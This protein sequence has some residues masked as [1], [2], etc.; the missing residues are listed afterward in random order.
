MTNPFLDIAGIKTLRCLLLREKER[1]KW[2]LLTK[3]DAQLKNRVKDVNT[4]CSRE[5]VINFILEK[6]QLRE[7]FDPDTIE[8]VMGILAINEFCLTLND[9]NR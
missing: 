9:Y 7:S 1:E 3:H 5:H 2:D 8:L 6:C 4:I